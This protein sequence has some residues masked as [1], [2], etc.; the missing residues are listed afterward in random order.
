VLD[1]GVA[2]ERLALEGAENHD[3]QGAREEIALFGG[4]R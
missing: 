4:F 1:Q 3:F 2:V